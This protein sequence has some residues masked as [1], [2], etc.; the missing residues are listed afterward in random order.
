MLGNAFGGQLVMLNALRYA[1]HIKS[2]ASDTY[3]CQKV[4][5]ALFQPHNLF[6]FYFIFSMNCNHIS[7]YSVLGVNFRLAWHRMT[8]QIKTI[9]NKNELA[10]QIVSDTRNNN[11]TD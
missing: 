11:F 5:E 2:V 1:S 4:G 8:N 6:Q 3:H 7:N 10:N 9:A